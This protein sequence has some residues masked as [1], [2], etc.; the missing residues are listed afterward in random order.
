[1][2]IIQFEM[3]NVKFKSV[4]CWMLSEKTVLLWLLLSWNISLIS[5]VLIIV[6]FH[7]WKLYVDDFGEMWN[8]FSW[9]NWYS[10]HKLT[11]MRVRKLKWCVNHKFCMK[12]GKIAT[13]ILKIVPKFN[14]IQNWL[15][16]D[17]YYIIYWI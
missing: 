5:I 2:K 10:K 13:K 12:V 8:I 7:V 9:S 11:R 14:I 15:I 1:M 6:E 3:Q 16:F 17:S 4:R